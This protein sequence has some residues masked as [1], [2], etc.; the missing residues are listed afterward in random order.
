MN[1]I[2]DAANIRQLSSGHVI[3]R[4]MF[5]LY[6]GEGPSVKDKKQCPSV[7]VNKLVD[8]YQKIKFHSSFMVL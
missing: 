6:L 3:S 7:A 2:T 4:G 5:P 8:F 1:S